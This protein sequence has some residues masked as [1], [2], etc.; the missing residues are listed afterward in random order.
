MKNISLLLVVVMVL[1]CCFALSSCGNNSNYNPEEVPT[2]EEL[3]QM[4][5]KAQD[6]EAN[7]KFGD[8]IKIYRQLNEYDFNDPD[9]GSRSKTVR[10]TRYINQSIA[11]KY[12]S[13]AVNS[14]KSQLKDPNSLVVYSMNINSESS[15]G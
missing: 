13:W 2:Q 10:E 14:L 7:A 9:F 12:F 15:S 8:A 5:N 1:G 6:Y 4:F 3:Q 11:C